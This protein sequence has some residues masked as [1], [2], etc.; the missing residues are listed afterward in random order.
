MASA[1]SATRWVLFGSFGAR[2]LAFFGQA[3]ILRLVSKEV[4]GAYGAIMAFPLMLMPLIPMGFD[5]LLIRE[6]HIA[7][8]YAMAL[9]WS[10]AM[11]GLALTATTLLIAA[12]LGWGVIPPLGD[13]LDAQALAVLSLIFLIFAAKQSIR[14][15]LA[16]RLEFKT[17]SIAEFGNGMITYFGGA[18]AVAFSPTLVALL[19]AYLAGEIFEAVWL[20]KGRR[21]RP[22]AMLQPRRF[23]VF[24]HLFRRHRKFCLANTADLTMNNMG[25]LLP[26]PFIVVLIS[27]E[28]NAD[29]SA[30]RMLIQLP[31]ML[32]AGAIWRV[33]Y[34]TISGVT[35]QV[36]HQRC[37]R[38]IGTTAAMLAP[39]VIWL[40]FFA[41]GL[42]FLLG[43][44]RYLSAAPLIQWMAVYMVL[45]SIFNPISSLDMIR[46][47]P[48]I[49]LYWNIGLTATRLGA[50]WWFAA[51]GLVPAIA[52]MSIASA[53]V[54]VGWAATLGWLL[55]CG[56]WRFFAAVAR[57]AP[58]WLLLAGAFWLCSMADGFLLPML[59]SVPVGLVY[60]AII[61]RYFPDEAS[62]VYRIVGIQR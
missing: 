13:A 22:L 49:G 54:W 45:V 48:E 23:W 14:S 17:I 30:A 43:G 3:I 24:T 26:A 46:D 5:Q 52:A 47:K 37:L 27:E 51:D 6:K 58:G 60:L 1:F 50:L 31:I 57:F 35:E 28:A 59:L 15:M 62:M 38:I 20:Y 44:E 21:F 36:L 39:A 61:L 2:A 7:R 10:L 40:G 11:W 12:A 42:A 41:P 9:A 18:L 16:A 29:F 55:R 33:A 25:S 56:A 53:V 4:F 34:P 19:V 8:R 32:L